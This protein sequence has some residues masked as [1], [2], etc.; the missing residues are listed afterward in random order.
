MASPAPLKY[1]RIFTSDDGESHLG[2]LDALMQAKMF[3]PPRS[4]SRRV[5]IRWPRLPSACS[6]CR[7]IGAAIGIRAPARQWLF[8]LA[9]RVE[10]EVSD[11]AIQ[12]PHPPAQSSFWRT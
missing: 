8:F 4:T 1:V 7:R 12:T 9:G 3:A 2:H 6:G 5:R 11:G 10:M